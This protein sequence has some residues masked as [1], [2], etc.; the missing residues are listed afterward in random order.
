MTIGK[1]EAGE[2][3]SPTRRRVLTPMRVEHSVTELP[4]T[5]WLLALF[6]LTPS[7][8]VADQALCRLAD[9]RVQASDRTEL[10][11]PAPTQNNRGSTDSKFSTHC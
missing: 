10:V 3:A 2:A 1:N 6:G 7:H 4:T 8:C 9:F 11:E 5:D